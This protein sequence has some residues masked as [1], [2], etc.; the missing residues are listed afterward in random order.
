[1]F[2]KSIALLAV[3]AGLLCGAA[4]AEDALAARMGHEVYPVGA[5]YLD[6]TLEAP[7]GGI[8]YYAVPGDIDVK[9]DA[10]WGEEYWEAVAGA[11]DY[12]G[13]NQFYDWDAAQRT[14]VEELR[15]L[16]GGQIDLV[17]PLK[18]LAPLE[19][20]EYRLCY[21]R[22]EY[23][24]EALYV[25]FTVSAD[26]EPLPEATEPVSE[27]FEMPEHAPAHLSADYISCQDVSTWARNSTAYFQIGDSVYVWRG[28]HE[29]EGS[30]FPDLWWLFRYPAGHPEQA[31]ALLN[32]VE[33]VMHNI[34]DTG[35]GWLIEDMFDDFCRMDYDGQS[36]AA[37]EGLD[38]ARDLLA[39]GG[40]LYFTRAD[41]V[42]R[43]PLDTL[44]P[45]RVYAATLMAEDEDEDAGAE[46]VPDDEDWDAY[47]E[48]LLATP[49]A[50]VTMVYANGTLYVAD[51]GIVAIDARTLEARRLTDRLY[52]DA[53]KAGYAFFI[54]G[55]QLYTCLDK[56]EGMVSLN[57][58]GSDVQPVASEVY[59]AS[60]IWNGTVLAARGHTSGFLS[61]GYE[62]VDFYLPDDPLNP[63]FDPEHCQ[64][65]PV[66]KYDFMLGDW[67]YHNRADGGVDVLQADV[68]RL[69]IP[70]V[71]E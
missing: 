53:G 29:C 59:Y 48:A 38:G 65:Q 25:H 5:A 36:L 13:G 14:G 54:V 39:A 67:M 56:S 63:N 58:D 30:W 8:A 51:S 49:D 28:L 22:D 66:Q 18:R 2:M 45:E 43:A 26:A 1:M 7:E 6:F 15:G 68:E 60:Q 42:W 21:Y 40:M 16:M 37:V 50:D 32:R 57:L 17:M 52:N 70:V 62:R 71:E 9:R 10:G 27:P 55:D 44:V 20:G 46:D 35:A 47:M 31:R 69:R 11:Y 12:C 61:G 41:G 34:I 4:L 23:E 3:M 24:D 64:T 33:I 19:A